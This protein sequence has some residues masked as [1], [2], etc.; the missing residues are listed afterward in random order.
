[1]HD[2]IMDWGQK[3]NMCILLTIFSLQFLFLSQRAKNLS[4]LGQ[5][6]IKD[7]LIVIMYHIRL[8]LFMYK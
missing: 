1:M 4:R 7:K 6:F 2:I 5:T 3:Y 8:F